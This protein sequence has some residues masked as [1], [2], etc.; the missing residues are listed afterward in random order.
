MPDKIVQSLFFVY[1]SVIEGTLE[2]VKD[3]VEKFNDFLTSF[4]TTKDFQG[5][6]HFFSQ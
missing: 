2:E 6:G 4:Y 3:I 5:Y 1:L